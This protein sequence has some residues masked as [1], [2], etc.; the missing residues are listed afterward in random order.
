MLGLRMGPDGLCWPL[1]SKVCSC[2][3]LCYRSLLNHEFWLVRNEWDTTVTFLLIPASHGV[4][5]DSLV[6][7][8]F[9]GASD[10][11]GAVFGQEVGTFGG[12]PFALLVCIEKTE[13]SGLTK[14]RFEGKVPLSGYSSGSS[15]R[16][17][18]SS[19]PV[20]C[21]DWCLRVECCHLW[22]RCS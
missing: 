6:G 12:L 22:T 21:W 15:Y 19:D 18:F 16:S 1:G 8:D 3:G 13:L 10:V 2:F 14:L 4:V 20:L 7:L 11:L 17:G 9:V 5:T